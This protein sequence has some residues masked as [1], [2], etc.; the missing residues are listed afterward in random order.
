MRFAACMLGY[1]VNVW[2]IRSKV[3]GELVRELNL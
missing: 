2:K 3:I 1:L